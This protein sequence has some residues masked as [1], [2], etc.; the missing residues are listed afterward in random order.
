MAHSHL[1]RAS[2]PHTTSTVG[3][4]T[5]ET[6]HDIYLSNSFANEN[7]AQ[8][9]GT[10]GPASIQP[11]LGTEKK[12]IFGLSYTFSDVWNVLIEYLRIFY[13]YKN[14]YKPP[15]TFWMYVEGGD[16]LYIHSEWNNPLHRP[17]NAEALYHCST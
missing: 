14:L 15:L 8:M 6:F 1:P 7:N 17:Q 4:P 13:T 2:W 9:P 12:R 5:Q 3:R 10:Y 11:I 16:T